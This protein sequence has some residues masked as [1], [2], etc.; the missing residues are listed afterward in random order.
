MLKSLKLGIVLLVCLCAVV[1]LAAT[2]CGNAAEKVAEKIVEKA[3]ESE[4]NGDVDIDI[5]SDE[6]EIKISSSEGD[7]NMKTGG[8]AEWPDDVPSYIPQFDGDI[9]QVIESESDGQKHYSIVYEN[10][11]NMDADDYADDLEGKGWDVVSKVE[12][13]TAW[14]IQATRG[15]NEDEW[16][17]ATVNTDEDTGSIMY[18]AE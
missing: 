15:D 11:D 2:S 17:N 18:V 1:T 10:L 13:G 12:M 6:G 7:F 8:K 5:D 16:V 14:M 9:I 4:G 3:I